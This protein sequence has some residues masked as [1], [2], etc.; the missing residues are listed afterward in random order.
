MMWYKKAV[1]AGAVGL[2]SACNG[3]VIPDFRNLDPMTPATPVVAPPPPVPP[4]VRV[5]SAIEGQGCVLR[6]E[7]RNAVQLASNLTLPELEATITR[8]S[9]LGRVV[10]TGDGGLRVVTER[11]TA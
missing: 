9:E 5:V 3:M 2:L 6:A 1:L 11:C 4:E 7:N 8:L 10:A